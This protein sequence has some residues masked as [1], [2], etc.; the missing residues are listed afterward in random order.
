[1]KK[2][3]IGKEKGMRKNERKKNITKQ[4]KKEFGAEMPSAETHDASLT[5]AETLCGEATVRKQCGNV[6]FPLIH[7]KS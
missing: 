5:G 6:V 7:I 1:M 2:W 3:K 4:R